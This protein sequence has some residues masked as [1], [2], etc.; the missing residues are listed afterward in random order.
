M[1]SGRGIRKP[2]WYGIPLRAVLITFPVTLMSFAMSL[3][4]GIIG[5][6]VASRV[7][8]VKLDITLA[9]RHVA[10]PVAVVVGAIVLIFA[11]GTEIR[12]YR[13]AKTLHRLER[14][15]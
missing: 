2:H 6:V 8:H 13:Q 4:L 9:Y 11:L 1:Q 7:R 3:L 12:Q 10:F 14:A 5:T 15:G